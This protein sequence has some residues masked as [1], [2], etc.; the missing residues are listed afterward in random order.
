[1]YNVLRA[2]GLM[3]RLGIHASSLMIMRTLIPLQRA[4]TRDTNIENIEK[5]IYYRIEREV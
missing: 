2:R 4:N 3:S 1:M 5:M